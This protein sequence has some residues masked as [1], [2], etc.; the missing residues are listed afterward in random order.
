MTPLG[1]GL[2]GA[3]FLV[4]SLLALYGLYRLSLV[5]I[6]LRSRGP[7]DRGRPVSLAPASWPPVTVQLPVFNEYYVVERLIEAACNLRYP[8][9]RLEI[10][11]LDDSTDGTRALAARLVESYRARGVDIHHMH[12]G[13]REGYKAGALAAGLA[14]AR[15]EVIVVFDA[16]FIPPPDFL[17]RCVP[18][19]AGPGS[20]PR[21][22][23]VQARWGHTN[24]DHSML[25]RAQAMMLDGHFVVEHRARQSS[26]RF[27]NF[28]GTAGAF[29]RRCIEQAGGWQDDTLTEDLDLSYRAQLAGWRFECLPD[30]E[31]PAEL[32]VE[33]DSLKSQQRRWAR[34]SIQTARKLLP[35]VLASALPGAVKLEAVVHLTN[36][37]AYLLTALLAVL[38]VP[39]LAA[40][41]GRTWTYLA[42]DL[43]LLLAG[44]GSFSLYC[45]VAQRATRPDW[46]KALLALPGLMALGIGLCINNGVAVLEGL[47]GSPSGFQRTPKFRVEGSSVSRGDWMA[48]AY[49]GPRSALILV[50]AAFATY[51]IAAIWRGI[52]RGSYAAL[53]F[54]ALFACGFL[55]VT[56][57]SVGQDMARRLIVRSGRPAEAPAP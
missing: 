29:R 26:G 56:A 35:K 8:E 51:F 53:P 25:T 30:L 39:A 45:L 28:N 17:L 57:L 42:L 20:D 46:V 18:R 52:A 38:I 5:W 21:L 16:D 33:I 6:Y 14:R 4:L 24:R 55:Y 7:T 13:G 9:G 34:G 32:P 48:L 22:G 11:L 41:G 47:S 1:L 2:Q 40:R 27:L 43:P 19:L 3:Y 54:L 31:V 10:Q 12:R 23:M 37:A 15:G 49:R 44:T 36:N 50:E